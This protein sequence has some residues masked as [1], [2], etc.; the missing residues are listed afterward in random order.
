MQVLSHKSEFSSSPSD[1]L[2]SNFDTNLSHF[3]YLRFTPELSFERGFDLA[4]PDTFM[5]PNQRVLYLLGGAHQ[6]VKARDR[7]ARAAS[8]FIY[9]CPFTF[10][11]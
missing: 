11:Q 6:V 4:P 10:V 8:T 3:T 9:R 5:V 2:G 1:K 7:M